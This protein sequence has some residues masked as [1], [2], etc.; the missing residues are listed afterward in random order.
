MLGL[1]V[2]FFQPA[3][4]VG[5][6]RVEFRYIW[7]DVQKRSLIQDVNV[8]DGQDRA[9]GGQKADDGKADLARPV[10]CPGGEQT[11]GYGIHEGLDEELEAGTLVKVI[12]ENDVG[13]TLEV[14]EA[15]PVLFKYMH[16]SANSLGA[17][18]LYGHALQ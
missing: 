3:E 14:L 12:Q 8:F 5:R 13:K 10:R 15:F 6:C 17:R 16:L 1:V 9:F 11:S 4:S 7:L 18:G 2:T